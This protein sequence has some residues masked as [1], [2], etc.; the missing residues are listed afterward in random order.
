M[1]AL[2]VRSRPSSN[3]RAEMLQSI[4]GRVGCPPTHRESLRANYTLR[5]FISSLISCS[6][7][8]ATKSIR[9]AAN[10]VSR[11]GP[12]ACAMSENSTKFPR[13]RQHRRCESPGRSVQ[14][15][16]SEAEPG[17]ADQRASIRRVEA[18]ADF[19]L[20]G[21]LGDWLLFNPSQYETAFR[22]LSATASVTLRKPSNPMN[23][24]VLI[25][26]LLHQRD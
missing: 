14:V 8:A 19:R 5:L 1:V 15:A 24:S 25:G 21:N 3:Q 9:T 10:C 22:P 13:E 2:G 23:G 11:H 4:F 26:G 17:A 16:R 7:R 18:A 6:E 20:P 12:Y